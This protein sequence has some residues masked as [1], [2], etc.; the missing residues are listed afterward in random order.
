[1]CVAATAANMVSNAFIN[2]ATLGW[3][4]WALAGLMFA[5]YQQLRREGLIDGRPSHLR[6]AG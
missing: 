2:R 4:F 6:T 5:E 1:M 3:F